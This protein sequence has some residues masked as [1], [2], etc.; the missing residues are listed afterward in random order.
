MFSRVSNL[1][2]SAAFSEA[3]CA[4]KTLLHVRNESS[5]FQR[6]VRRRQ[7]KEEIKVNTL[8]PKFDHSSIVR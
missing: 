4:P 7:R 1:T 5:F 6:G 3:Q 2:R 8:I